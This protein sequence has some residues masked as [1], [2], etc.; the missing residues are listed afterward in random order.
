MS[1]SAGSFIS[2]K[3]LVKSISGADVVP[4]ALDCGP[5]AMAGSFPVA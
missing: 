2:A 5:L 3:N 4:P 1:G